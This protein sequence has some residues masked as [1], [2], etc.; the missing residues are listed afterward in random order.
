MTGWSVRFRIYEK[1]FIG[2]VDCPRRSDDAIDVK[3]AGQKLF[4]SGANRRRIETGWTG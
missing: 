1:E 3:I 2:G 4:G